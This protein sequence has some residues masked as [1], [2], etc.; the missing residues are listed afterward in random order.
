[1]H[2]L[3]AAAH[4]ELLEGA[5]L[6]DDQVHQSEFVWKAHKDEEATGVQSHTVCLFLE[7]L[8]QLQHSDIL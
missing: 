5:D 1:M 4:S 8:V 6:I 3:S 2:H 7:L